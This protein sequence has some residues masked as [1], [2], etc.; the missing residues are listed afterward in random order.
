MIRSR[1]GEVT[2]LVLVLAACSSDGLGKPTVTLPPS[3][4]DV[5]ATD[6]NAT[7]VGPNECRATTIGLRADPPTTRL[8]SVYTPL[9]LTNNGSSACTLSTHLSVSFIDDNGQTVGPAPIN[10]PGAGGTDVISLAAGETQQTVLSYVEPKSLQ[11][12]TYTGHTSA[13]LVINDT[14]VLTLPPADWPL[15]IVPAVD[16]VSLIDIGAPG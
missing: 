4:G 2:F 11:C 16:Q 9:L 8:D 12:S 13:R 3:S 1:L 15:C 7:T 6:T 10:S 5:A 14:E